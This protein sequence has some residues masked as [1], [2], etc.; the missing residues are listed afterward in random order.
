MRAYLAELGIRSLNPLLSEAGFSTRTARPL[1]PQEVDGLNPLLSEAGFST[2]MCL[3][4]EERW[5]ERLNPLLSDAGF[6]TN[7]FDELTHRIR[8]TS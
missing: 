1:P 7:T 2:S 4:D 5:S 8:Y 6:S 3:S